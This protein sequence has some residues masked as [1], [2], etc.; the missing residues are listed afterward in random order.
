MASID[1]ENAYYCVPIAEEHRKYL[2][3]VWEGKTYQYT[4]F[5]NALAFCPRKFSKLILNQVIQN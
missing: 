5:P 3:F 1:L 2:R 4:C